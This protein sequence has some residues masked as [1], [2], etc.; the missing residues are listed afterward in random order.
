MCDDRYSP[1]ISYTLSK[2]NSQTSKYTKLKVCPDII[3][4]SC[5]SDVFRKSYIDNDTFSFKLN[6]KER[7]FYFFV[8]GY[9]I[10][11]GQPII[12][13]DK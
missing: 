5:C 2:R 7:S 12:L 8:F 9:H 13:V 10:Y 6:P 1:N 11:N 3:P 4:C